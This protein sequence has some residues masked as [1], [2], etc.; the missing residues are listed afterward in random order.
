M[1]K[2]Q[3]ENEPLSPFFVG[4]GYE[5]AIFIYE[6]RWPLHYHFFEPHASI[7]TRCYRVHRKPPAS[8][9]RS[10][11]S[12]GRFTVT[13]KRPDSC[14]W[15]ERAP[16][17]TAHNLPQ[18]GPNSGSRNYQQLQSK[19][20]STVSKCFLAFREAISKI[21]VRGLVYFSSPDPPI[22]KSRGASKYLQEQAI[23]GPAVWARREIKARRRCRRKYGN[24]MTQW[25]RGV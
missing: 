12:T 5:A 21:S 3:T 17:P 7:H 16:N 24:S 8:S 25:E 10:K 15:Q 2:G 9:M 6:P 23:T 22:V 4:G 1:A 14:V 18:L 19:L 11:R 13:F 20:R